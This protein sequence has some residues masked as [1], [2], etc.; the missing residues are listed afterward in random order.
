MSREISS[1]LGEQ[2]ARIEAPIEEA[3]TLPAKTYTSEDFYDAEREKIFSKHWV[4][5]LFDFDVAD[6]GQALPFDLCDFAESCLSISIL[7]SE[8][9]LDSDKRLP[10][11]NAIAHSSCIHL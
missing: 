9:T 2:L 4:S 11:A 6:P 10:A 3:G 7:D 8:A 1:S 5:V